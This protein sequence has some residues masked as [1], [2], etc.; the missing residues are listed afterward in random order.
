MRVAT[1]SFGPFDVS[2]IQEIVEHIEEHDDGQAIYVEARGRL[3]PSTP[4]AVTS[5]WVTAADL[6]HDCGFRYLTDVD[7]AREMIAEFEG[8]RDEKALEQLLEMLDEYG[9]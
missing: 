5:K 7:E 8:A 1:S 2:T 9:C 6:V 4:A 3:L